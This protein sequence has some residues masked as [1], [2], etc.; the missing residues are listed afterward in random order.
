MEIQLCS[1]IIDGS[2]NTVAFMC[3]I[4]SEDLLSIGDDVEFFL[5]DFGDN[6]VEVTRASRGESR[7]FRTV[8]DN[9]PHNNIDS[10]PIHRIDAEEGEQ[11]VF[12][13]APGL[14]PEIREQRL[15]RVRARAEREAGLPVSTPAPVPTPLPEPAPIFDIPA[16]QVSDDPP[17]VGEVPNIV[18]DMLAGTSYGEED[19]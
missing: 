12:E 15:Q 6:R 14:S 7:Y 2:K 19:V 13:P 16:T 4:S 18:G 3:E 10:L 8:A 17:V 1:R 5:E 9:N 11:V